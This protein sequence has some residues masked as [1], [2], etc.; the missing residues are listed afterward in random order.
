[1]ISKGTII[2]PKMAGFAAM[3]FDFRAMATK[4]IPK[5]PIV[6]IDGNLGA[7]PIEEAIAKLQRA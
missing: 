3:V 5:T 4:T 1:M 7:M 6:D 2:D